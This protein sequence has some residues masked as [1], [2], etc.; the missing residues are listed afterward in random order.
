MSDSFDNLPKRPQQH[1]TE[2]K[3]VTA[4]RLQLNSELF[5]EQ[6]SS[7]ENDYGTDIIIEAMMPDNSTNIRI[8]IQLKGTEAD[9]NK[10]SSLSISN[11]A[12]ANVNYL[13]RQPSSLYIGFHVPSQK[14]FYKV[15]ED[16]IRDLEHTVP[17]WRKQ[18]TITVRFRDLFTSQAQTSFHERIIASAKTRDQD[19]LNLLSA[20]PEHI[21]EI[22]EDYIP[23]IDVPHDKQKALI[24]LHELMDN[25][26]DAIISKAHNQFSAVLDQENM[27]EF[28]FVYLAEINLA[29]CH[30]PHSEDVIR[31]GIS[32]FELQNTN[33]KIDLAGHFYNLGNAYFGLKDYTNARRYFISSL[34]KFGFEITFK[35]ECHKNLGSCYLELGR[36]RKAFQH[37]QQA[38]TLSPHLVEAHFALGMWHRHESNFNEA[39]NHF[40]KVT[41]SKNKHFNTTTLQGWRADILFQLSDYSSA[42]REMNTLLLEADKKKW[43][44][45]WCYKLVVEYRSSNPLYYQRALAFWEKFTEYFPDRSQGHYYKIHAIYCLKQLGTL[46]QH[47]FDSF[48]GLVAAYAEKHVE[49]VSFL[50]DRAGHW[51]QDDGDWINALDCY[52][53][54]CEKEPSEY[55]Y[56]LAVSLINTYQ[57]QEAVDILED[58]YLEHEIDGLYFNQLA[59]AKIQTGDYEG[60]IAVY[61]QSTE[62]EPDYHL[63][64]FELA[65]CYYNGQQYPEA[66]KYFEYAIATFPNETEFVDRA[67]VALQ[68]IE[69]KGH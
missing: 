29:V 36:H 37:Y 69:L 1:K 13:F 52:R 15:V 40:D 39:L 59:S 16:L 66:R 3:A 8:H 50:W 7:D 22:M 61:L 30:R 53:N 6:S 2:S 4:L 57:Y 60:A 67:N 9:L 35:A 17:E 56:C 45:P 18:E 48:R 20:P 23:N 21:L 38:I 33:Q 47:T 49:D 14:L 63:S 64:W 58:P 54:A 11:I 44:W 34:R 51:A 27:F 19:R 55:G 65:G 42:F 28:G 62:M 31:Q 41:I 12:T 32:V 26:H 5:L 68:F 10:D 24:Y 25:G 46:S 43:I